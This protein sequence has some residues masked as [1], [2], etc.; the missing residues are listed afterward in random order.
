MSQTNRESAPSSTHRIESAYNTIASEYQEAMQDE[1]EFKAL[2][3]ALLGAL[4]ELSGDGVVADVGCGPGHVTK[5]L[6]AKH[7]SVIGIDLAPEMVEIA[8]ASVPE[9]TFRVE[10]M[11]ALTGLL[12][13]SRAARS[14]RR[15][16]CSACR[17]R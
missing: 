17:A 8:R 10:A 2:D 1:L 16:Y 6:A 7:R 4:L 15:V 3:R 13:L 14:T 5:F 11:T 9:V 12:A